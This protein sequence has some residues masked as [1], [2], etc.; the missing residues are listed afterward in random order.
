MKKIIIG[1]VGAIL[2]TAFFA[3]GATVLFVPQGGTGAQ[4]FPI[5]NILIGNGTNAITSTSTTLSG[6][7]LRELPSFIVAAS[8]GD[9]TT[10]QGALTACG[11][12]GGGTIYLTDPTYNQGGTGLTFRGSNCNVYGRDASTTINFTGAT[13]GFKTNS[14]AG[15][16]SNN[17][18]H[19]VKI[20]GDGTSGSIGI[21]MSDMS[22]SIYEKIIMDNWDTAYRLNDTQN[23]TFYNIVRD[24][25]L[26]TLASFGINASSTKPTNDNTF[27]N[28]FIGCSNNTTNGCIAINLNNA[29][30]NSFLDVTAEP[31]GNTKTRCVQ[32]RAN[33]LANNNGTFSNG[34]HDFY[35]EG[36]TIGIAASTTVGTA[37]VFG[38]N[39]Y[40]GQIETNTTDV[41]DNSSGTS[42]VHFYG[43]G[44]NFAE[45][46]T[47]SANFGIGTST[48]WSALS[49]GSG[50]IVVPE[51][52]TTAAATINISFQNQ[53]TSKIELTATSTINLNHTGIP[54]EVQKVIV[55]QN[56]VGN[57]GATFAASSSLIWAGHTT[58]TQT[59]TANECD[60]YS[61]IV[62]GATGTPTVF[63]AATQI[64]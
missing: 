30:K 49:L 32:I 56:S 13:T 52:S 36:N 50:A 64:F 51:A 44:I 18:V 23:I 59:Q 62:T 25:T 34:F 39:F 35:C 55:C 26:T 27:E 16:Y 60:V 20:L 61:F 7:T 47:V 48:P 19:N 21:D 17:G 29:Q 57:W 63:G 37:V 10:I 42:T 40:G 14:A 33:S 12:A 54:G 6:F 46:N 41:L 31:A 22:H 24:G 3:Y 11:S 5:G 2:G 28:L 8:G 38:N 1:L 43:A 45:V 58:P 9:F 4:T 53:Q 15:L